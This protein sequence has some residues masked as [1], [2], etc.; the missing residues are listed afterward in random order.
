MGGDSSAWAS[1][2][3]MSDLSELASTVAL[4]GEEGAAVRTTVAAKA[5]TIRERMSAESEMAA[6]AVTERMSLPSVL[7]VLGFLVFLC[8]PALSPCCRSR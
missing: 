4:A 5:R 6:A 8:Y 1:T 3:A 2:W 7:L